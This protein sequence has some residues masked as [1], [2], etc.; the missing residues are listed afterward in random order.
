MYYVC[1]LKPWRSAPY[2]A[3]CLLYAQTSYKTVL[4]KMLQE[5]SSSELS[6]HLS[7]EY[8]PQFGSNKMFP[9]SHYRLF[10][11]YF[12]GCLNFWSPRTLRSRGCATRGPTQTLL[13]PSPLALLNSPQSAHDLRLSSVGRP[14]A[15]LDPNQEEGNLTSDVNSSSTNIESASHLRPASHKGVEEDKWECVLLVFF[16]KEFCLLSI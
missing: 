9:Y 11:D 14:Q 8:N 16:F 7:L 12:F 4:K 1:L 5:S 13:P 6:E 15:Q 2:H 3:W 10:I